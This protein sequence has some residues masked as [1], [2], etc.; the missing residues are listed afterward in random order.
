MHFRNFGKCTGTACTAESALPCLTTGKKLKIQR[1]RMKMLKLI[2]PQKISVDLKKSISN[3]VQ[4]NCPF[5]QFVHIASTH[6]ELVMHFYHKKQKSCLSKKE[7]NGVHENLRIK[8]SQEKKRKKLLAIKLLLMNESSS[9][10]F[11]LKPNCKEDCLKTCFFVDDH[12]C[13]PN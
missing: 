13:Y 7:E 3:S 1:I 4:Q 9:V 5:M 6:G 11:L 2:K 10:S 8:I 12:S